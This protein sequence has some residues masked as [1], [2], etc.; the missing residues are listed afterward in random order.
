MSSELHSQPNLGPAHS[1]K[2]DARFSG[3][4][5]PT[6]DLIDLAAS[7]THF[8]THMR[9]EAPAELNAIAPYLARFVHRRHLE[10]R[11]CR[12]GCSDLAQWPAP[13]F[14]LFKRDLS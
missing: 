11:N 13:S 9:A 1:V 2:A 7:Y 5:L 12:L 6:A 4:A 14:Q 10:L 3:R 8:F